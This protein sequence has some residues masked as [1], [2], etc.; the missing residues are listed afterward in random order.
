MLEAPYDTLWHQIIVMPQEMKMWWPSS[1]NQ[2]TLSPDQNLY[3]PDSI[4]HYRRLR[5]MSRLRPI[6][7]LAC[8]RACDLR[9]MK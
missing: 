4:P 1:H 5:K 2:S 9:A 8:F 6:P 7:I 3:I